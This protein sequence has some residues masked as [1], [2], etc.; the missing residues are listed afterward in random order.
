MDSVEASK[1]LQALGI[2]EI[3]V[4]RVDDASEFEHDGAIPKEATLGHILQKEGILNLKEFLLLPNADHLD[5]EFISMAMVNAVHGWEAQRQPP[6]WFSRIA[7]FFSRRIDTERCNG[8][9]F[10]A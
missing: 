5:I 4:Q 9:S 2:P 8:R 3:I 1:K 10:G 6:S 7:S